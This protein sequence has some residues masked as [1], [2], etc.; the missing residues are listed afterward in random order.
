VSGVL[1]P[2]QKWKPLAA[3]M[4]EFARHP[5]LVRT[6]GAAARRRAEEV[7]DVRLVNARILEYLDP[8]NDAA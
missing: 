2:P 4:L 7:Y 6:M 5:E 3:R 8:A 1:V